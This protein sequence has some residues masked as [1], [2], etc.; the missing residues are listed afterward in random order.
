MTP[1]AVRRIK[2]SG[3]Q[4]SQA[5]SKGRKID[6]P[7]EEEESLSLALWAR[8]MVEANQEP[9]L[10][11]LRCGFEGLRLPMG[12]RMKVKRQSVSTGWPDFFLAV[13]KFEPNYH[14]CG[15]FIE[16]KREKGG[17]VSSDQCEIIA[18]LQEQG[19]S[20]CV[21][22]GATEAIRVIKAYLDMR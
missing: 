8:M 22:K 18:L 10:K 11:L 5:A 3:P 20:A 9:R 7:T 17:A 12:L 1:Q 19:Y 4:E 14:R 13:P 15:L 21:C 6:C 16:L 2:N